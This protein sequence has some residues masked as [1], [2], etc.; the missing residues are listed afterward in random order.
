MEKKEMGDK[1]GRVLGLYTRLLQGDTINKAGESVRYGVSERSIQRDIDDIREFLDK[2][3]VESGEMNTVIYDHV[4]QGYRLEKVAKNMLSNGE[5][6]GLCKI[7][8]DSRA[9][10]KKELMPMIDHLLECCVPSANRKLLKELIANE[11]YH[12]VELQ[13]GSAIT[14]RLWDIGLAIKECQCIEV[15]YIKVKDQSMVTRK[16]K[17]VGMMFSEFYFYLAAYIVDSKKETEV[18]GFNDYPTIYRMDRIADYTILKEHFK[19]PYKERFE[20]GEFR[21]RVQFMYSGKLRRIKFWY[22]GYDIDAILD[23]LPTANVLAKDDNGWMVQA[24]VYGSG[25]D[26][27]LR[28][29]GDYVK[30]VDEK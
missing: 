5:V 2:N 6:L 10:N 8:L 9:F 17:P 16:L 20:E 13:H 14:G 21:K 28:S 15:K 18:D 22:T 1:N 24:E 30:V 26:M 11:T 12:Y 7:L 19:I 29:Q 25:I 3:S 23:R 27:W 4:L